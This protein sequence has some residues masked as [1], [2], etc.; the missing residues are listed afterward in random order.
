MKPPPTVAELGE[1]YVA[2]SL[3][4]LPASGMALPRQGPD[5]HPGRGGGGWRTYRPFDRTVA[6]VKE[7]SILHVA[8]LV[9]QGTAIRPGTG[10][11][12]VVTGEYRLGDVRHVVASPEL[13]RRELGFRAAVTPEQGLAAL[14]TEPLRAC[15]SPA[16]VEQVLNDER[17]PELD[18]QSRATPTLG[19][20]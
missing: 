4:S 9:A 3:T 14:A 8:E 11:W 16:G 15:A 13:A 19:Q 18:S 7:V 6:Q 1:E 10:P 20:G 17:D 12:P 2:R 5:H